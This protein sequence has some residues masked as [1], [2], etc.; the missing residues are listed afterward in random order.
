MK[1]LFKNERLDKVN[2]K[3]EEATLKA[4]KLQSE[5]DEINL[6][7][8]QTFELYAV[9]DIDEADV[10]AAEKLLHEKKTKLASTI[11]MIGKL[12][13]VRKPI[14]VESI[15]FVKEARAKK[16]EAI[17]K[18]Y[19]D[20]VKNV[21]KARAAFLEELAALG[22]I[23]SEVSSINVEYNDLMVEMGE[24]PTVY[25]AAINETAVIS[26]GFTSPHKALGV[27]EITQKQTYTSGSVPKDYR[28][29]SK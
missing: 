27:D 1:R 3:I 6:A 2:E 12:K 25:G 9:G 26:G 28:G 5:I 7:L 10:Q 17:Q 18:K 22:R 4:E 15:P 19:D 29:D 11:E 13:A 8:T 20:Q 24:S 16:T 14:A 23:K 21:H